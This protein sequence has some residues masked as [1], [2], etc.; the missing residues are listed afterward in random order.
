MKRFWPVSLAV[1]LGVLAACDAPAPPPDDGLVET[2][3]DL[4][5]LE[6][7]HEQIGDVPNSVRDSLLA[8]HGYSAATL[9]AQ[10]DRIT[11]DLAFGDTVYA[12][13]ERRIEARRQ[14][15]ESRER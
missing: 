5:L 15:L 9:R 10:M 8:A 3:A 7:R 6:A 4:H 2:L 11:R 13:V 12:R 1:G 14:A